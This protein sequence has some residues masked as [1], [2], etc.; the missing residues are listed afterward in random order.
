M[1]FGSQ[2]MYI[3]RGEPEAEEFEEPEPPPPPP[4]V[5]AA[6]TPRP[7]SS[8]SWSLASQKELRL[9]IM[10]AGGVGKSALAISFVQNHFIEEYD[11]TIEDSYRKQVCIDGETML[12]DILDTAGQEEYS[13]MRDQYMRT[14]QAFLVVYSISSR[15]SFEEAT[16]MRDHV[17][18]IKDAATVPLLLVGNKCD[19]EV[20]RQVTRAEGEELARSWGLPFIE[21]SAKSRIN[22]EE[23]FFEL[24]RTYNRMFSVKP[25]AKP[26]KTASSSGFWSKLFGRDETPATTTPAAAA[27]TPKKPAKMRKVEISSTN[28][29]LVS[30]GDLAEPAELMTGEP[31][32]CAC[33]SV[34]T[35]ESKLVKEDTR[36]TG[37]RCQFCG[38]NNTVSLVPEE[39]PKTTTVDFILAPPPADAMADSLVVFLIDVSGSMC[40][41]T[42]VP[43]IQAEW[44][45]LRMGKAKSRE[46]E[47]GNY[48]S[49]LQCVKAAVD[50]HFQRLQKQHP[51]KKVVLLT[52]SNGVAIYGDGHAPETSIEGD[53]L[54]EYETLWELGHGMDLNALLPISK[55]REA[56][57]K[58]VVS[59]EEEGAT[60][61]GPA[62]VIAVGLCAQ[63]KSRSEIIIMTDGL[64]NVGLGA[65]EIN[66]PTQ[67]EKATTF[68]TQIG[69]K[70]LETNSTISIIGLEGKDSGHGQAADS[71]S[72]D[73]ALEILGN[74]SDLTH[75]T[76]NIVNPLELLR[77]IR[78]IHQ[79]PIIATDVKLSF[80]L[81]PTVEVVDQEYRIASR[82][83]GMTS[84]PKPSAAATDSDSLELEQLL[85]LLKKKKQEA[86]DAEDFDVAKQ[87]KADIALCETLAEI[88]ERKKKAIQD[89]DY[90][91]AK[92]LK[93]EFSQ[94]RA[95]IISVPPTETTS[96]TTSTSAPVTTETTSTSSSKHHHHHH[97]AAATAT[98]ATPNELPPQLVIGNANAEMDLTYELQAKTRD[99]PALRDSFPHS[100]PV[101]VQMQYT[102]LTG[103]KNLRVVTRSWQTTP[104]RSAAEESVNVSIVGLRAL[105]RSAYL[106][107][108]KEYNTARNLVFSTLQMLK[109]AAKTDIQMEEYY[110]TTRECEPL[111]QQLQLAIQNPKTASSDTTAKLLY[112]CKSSTKNMLLSGRLKTAAVKHRQVAKALQE[113]VQHFGVETMY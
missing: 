61:L 28:I 32:F 84:A 27:A 31:C 81:P 90:S 82:M 4:T 23:S 56:L 26:K 70:A 16:T 80:A 96:T 25:A 75:G 79:N 69:E 89:E 33:G 64:S 111:D 104:N 83:S 100:I 110:S 112:K 101:Q 85:Q 44:Q 94:T 41:T 40:V 43:E 37:W 42:E 68:Y 3:W 99:N 74:C 113:E 91:A 60:A 72:C 98:A 54:Q 36:I 108:R 19:L 71:T 29:A 88:N 95:K 87:V 109:R 22:V 57:S 39:I 93:Q 8:S 48:V 17:L 55:S 92:E 38:Q 47:T 59:L 102:T 10:G 9:V 1:E 24:V 49:R 30:L 77:Q 6:A 86:L 97:K 63:V 103:Q 66:N 14:G 18:R 52:F 5:T 2:F 20:Q 34:L 53:K 76:V 78:L 12:L 58:K 50:T 106:A 11:P 62:L 13:A 73:V 67:K 65:L 46:G 7:S 35:S 105:H 107:S 45:K 15:S 51:N 21:T